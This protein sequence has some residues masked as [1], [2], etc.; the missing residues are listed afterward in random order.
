M[1]CGAFSALALFFSRNLI[2][3][4]Y[5]ISP[6]TRSLS[7]LFITILAISVLGS[8]YEAPCLLGI[9]SGGGDTAFVLKN[10]LIFMWCFVLPLSALLL[11]LFHLSGISWPSVVFFFI[12]GALAVL[13]H[14]SNIQRLMDGT[15]N[16]FSGDKK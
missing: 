16:R 5:M 2:V 12:L 7:V 4:L 9:V 11:K 3:D 6:E 10:D 15:E 13:K 14:K 8:A 1:L